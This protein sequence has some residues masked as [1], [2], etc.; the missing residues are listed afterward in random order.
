MKALIRIVPVIC[1]YGMAANVSRNQQMMVVMVVMVVMVFRL[2]GNLI[3]SLHVP[4]KIVATDSR[5]TVGVR[6]KILCGMAQNA[7]LETILVSQ[8]QIQIL[9][10]KKIVEMDSLQIVVVHVRNQ[11]GMAVNV[12]REI[13]RNQSI[14][15][16]KP[17][18]ILGTLQSV[19]VPGESRESIV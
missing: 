14:A 8:V 2:Q 12:D 6:V 3:Q 5:R 11:F 7:D 19:R 4:K 17:R 16:N 9:Q 18:R 15:E 1:Q 13:N 10:V